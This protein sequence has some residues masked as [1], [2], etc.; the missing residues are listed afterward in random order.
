MVSIYIQ[1]RAEKIN[2]LALSMPE[3]EIT[4]LKEMGILVLEFLKEAAPHTP[5]SQIYK[6]HLSKCKE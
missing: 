6:C 5:S 2:R 3:L 1:R 4:A